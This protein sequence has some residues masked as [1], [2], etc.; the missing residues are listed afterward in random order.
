MWK[1]I[2]EQLHSERGIRILVLLGT[3][4]LGLILLSGLLPERNRESKTAENS[5]A[6]ED[7]AAETQ[8]YCRRM[9]E[10]L[11]RILEQVEGVGTCR[12]LVNAAGTAETR[13]VQDAETDLAESRQQSQQKCVILSDSSGERALVQQIVSP[14]I[15]GVV[16][17][18]SGA[19]SSV[20]QER[21]S[22]AVQA[23]LSLSSSRICVVPSAGNIS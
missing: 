11:S 17:V 8:Q 12:V 16:V 1:K 5:V 18:C 9:E 10:E 14:E 15:S 20:V 7:A 3:A 21:V 4:G 22:K 19:S 23:V 2:R 6:T 13:Y